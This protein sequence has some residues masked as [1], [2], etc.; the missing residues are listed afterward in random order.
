MH[1]PLHQ[2]LNPRNH[3]IH[4]Q[5]KREKGKERRRA[6]IKKGDHL[7]AGKDGA[8]SKIGVDNRATPTTMT[9]E[10]EGG[11]HGSSRAIRNGGSIKEREAIIKT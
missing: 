6:S 2:L 4:H 11:S 3:L 8:G 10:T 5:T 1:P 7:E 9:I